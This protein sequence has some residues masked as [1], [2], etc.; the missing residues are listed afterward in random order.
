MYA[1][2]IKVG[3]MLT[4]RAYW[5]IVY[6]TNWK[7]WVVRITYYFDTTYAIMRVIRE[8]QAKV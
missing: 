3:T 1:T 6:N 2:N 5:Y 4:D 7:P 8:I